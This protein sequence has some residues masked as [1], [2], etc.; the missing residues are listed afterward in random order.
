MDIVI[1]QP[2]NSET[3]DMHRV[4]VFKVVRKRR[5]HELD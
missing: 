5:Q 2:A 4:R 3:R 1:P